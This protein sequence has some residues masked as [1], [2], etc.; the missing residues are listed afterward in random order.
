MTVNNSEAVPTEEGRY[1]ESF[2]EHDP[3]A[4]QAI[5]TTTYGQ[6]IS[7]GQAHKLAAATG[8]EPSVPEMNVDQLRAEVKRLRDHVRKLEKTDG[9]MAAAAAETLGQLAAMTFPNG[10]AGILDPSG[11]GAEQQVMEAESSSMAS[12]RQAKHDVLS[13]DSHDDSP[14]ADAP[15]E[16][17][18]SLDYTFQEPGRR[19]RKRKN[20]EEQGSDQRRS[21]PVSDTT[22]K[23]LVLRERTDQLAVRVVL[24]HHSLCDSVLG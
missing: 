20:H 13:L 6:D 9:A 16:S 14:T 23:R 1:H 10:P 5:D 18:A 7:L 2:T 22:G 4:I 11:V 3:H 24:C 17:S 15:Q 12:A 19:G 21:V 8:H